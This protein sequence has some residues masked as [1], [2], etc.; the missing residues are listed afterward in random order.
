MLIQKFSLGKVSVYELISSLNEQ[1]N[2][3]HRYFSTI[4]DTY[5]NYFTLRSMAFFN[6]YTG[7]TPL[8]PPYV[9]TDNNNTPPTPY[10]PTSGGG[11]AGGGGGYDGS[12]SGNYP[13]D[14]NQPVPQD[15]YL[16]GSPQITVL[17]LSQFKGFKSS[18]SQGCL[19]RCDEMLALVGAHRSGKQIMMTNLSD[20]GRAGTAL[21]NA[22]TG[23]N[24]INSTL[25][26]SGKPIIVC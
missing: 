8:I 25:E 15:P 12:T 17:F 3:L 9:P 20:N 18:D 14:P 24:I 6:T 2:I 13:T 16:G 23:I 1:N 11:N 19:R 10:P 22:Q 5:N 21:S 7:G 26:N 4:R